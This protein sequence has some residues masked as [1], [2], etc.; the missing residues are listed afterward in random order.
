MNRRAMAAWLYFLAVVLFLSRYV[1]AIWYR[2]SN[3]NVW[4]HDNFAQF[5]DYVGVMPWVLA[6]VC[7]IAGIV[8]AVLAER[9]K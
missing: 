9:E 5:L 3:F 4:G 1:F 8:Y 2:G 6:V 7:L